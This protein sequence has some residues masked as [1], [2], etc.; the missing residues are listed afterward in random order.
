MYLSYFQTIS[1]LEFTVHVFMVVLRKLKT[2][3]YG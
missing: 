2:L 1:N 3:S